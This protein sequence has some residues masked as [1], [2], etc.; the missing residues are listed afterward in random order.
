MNN[1]QIDEIPPKERL[2]EVASI[3][4]TGILRLKNGR[5]YRKRESFLL[6]KR[7]KQSVHEENKNS[8]K[9]GDYS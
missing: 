1:T 8:E 6:D 3:L 4:A 5:N 2:R 7:S 9:T